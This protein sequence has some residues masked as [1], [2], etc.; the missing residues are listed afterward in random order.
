VSKGSLVAIALLL[1]S[2]GRGGDAGP[3][4]PRVH[5]LLDDDRPAASPVTRSPAVVATTAHD[6]A[7]AGRHRVPRH[8][9]TSGDATV[10]AMPADDSVDPGDT[11][12]ATLNYAIFSGPVLGN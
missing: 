5:Y 1:A 10:A 9:R 6:P 7:P 2:C 12:N 3:E 4:K 8:T 11:G